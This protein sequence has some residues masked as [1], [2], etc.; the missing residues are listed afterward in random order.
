MTEFVVKFNS[1]FK[2]ASAYALAIIAPILVFLNTLSGRL[3]K[4]KFSAESIAASCDGSYS[5]RVLCEFGH[6]L[7]S[8]YYSGNIL[9]IFHLLF[10]VVALVALISLL[11]IAGVEHKK[12]GGL[13][14][15]LITRL[16][17]RAYS[18]VGFLGNLQFLAIINLM[19]FQLWLPIRRTVDKPFNV[20]KKTFVKYL[21][22]IFPILFFLLGLGFLFESIPEN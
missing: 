7:A 3:A 10:L 6:G 22:V 15:M 9:P 5:Y 14:D 18:D 4:D 11:R 16:R 19:E 8:Y 12:G 13:I 17:H 1:H 2:S 21:F 20:A